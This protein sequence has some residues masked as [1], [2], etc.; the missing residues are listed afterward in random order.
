MFRA[1][2]VGIAEIAAAGVEQAEKVERVLL[3]LRL[4]CL[5]GID[6]Q[7]IVAGY[8]QMWA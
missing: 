4:D 7:N 2:N 5:V 3:L 8:E 6:Y 1:A